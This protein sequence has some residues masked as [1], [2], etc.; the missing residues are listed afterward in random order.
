M[1]ERPSFTGRGEIGESST[2]AWPLP[3]LK[4]PSGACM[5]PCCSE[6]SAHAAEARMP[7]GVMLPARPPAALPESN[8]HARVH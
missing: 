1:T 5:M 4:C 8:R 2:T 6:R 3:N 7:K